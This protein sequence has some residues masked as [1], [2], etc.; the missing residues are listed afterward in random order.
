MSWETINQI[1]GLATLDDAFC[2]A[3]LKHP[4]IAIQQWGFQLTLAEKE[5]LS[6]IT[7]DTLPAFTQCV[8]DTLASRKAHHQDPPGEELEELPSNND[9]NGRRE[10]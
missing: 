7:V 10:P 9:G 1:L 8:F 4:L 5:A 3:L 2:Q 6:Q